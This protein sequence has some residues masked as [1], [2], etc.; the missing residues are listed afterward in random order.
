MSTHLQRETETKTETETDRQR[1]SDRD[2][3]D[4]DGEKQTETDGQIPAK[5]ERN[6]GRDHSNRLSCVYNSSM[7]MEKNNSSESKN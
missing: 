5:T 6:T 4:R 7:K 3:R 2:N 1:Q